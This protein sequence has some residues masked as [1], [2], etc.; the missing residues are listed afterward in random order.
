MSRF[1]FLS[2]GAPL[3]TFTIASWL[4]LSHV[5]KDRFVI[6]VQPLRKSRFS[7]RVFQDARILQMKEEDFDSF[8]DKKT[9]RK[10]LENELV[11][12]MMQLDIDHYEN[13]PVPR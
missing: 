11:H 5:L 12:T 9:K 3:I 7:E 1:R 4:A 8:S 2:A 6:K 13:K 10:D